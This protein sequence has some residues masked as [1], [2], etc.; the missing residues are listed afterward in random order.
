MLSDILAAHLKLNTNSEQYFSQQM[1]W[2]QLLNHF[3]KSL[4]YIINRLIIENND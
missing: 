1:E 3:L 2:K 4:I